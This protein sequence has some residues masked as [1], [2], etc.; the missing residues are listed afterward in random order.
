MSTTTPPGDD[1]PGPIPGSSETPP[2]PPAFPPPPVSDSSGTGFQAG[3]PLDEGRRRRI[4]TW[5]VIGAIVLAAVV[6]LSLILLL[7]GGGPDLSM[8]ESLA[9]EPQIHGPSVDFII[10][11]A[12]AQIEKQGVK[13]VVGVYG[14]APQPRFMVMAIDRAVPPGQDPLQ[15]VSTGFSA[16]MLGASG[17]IDTSSVRR[18]TVAG[19]DYECAPYSISSNQTPV[20][21]SA[22][23]CVWDDGETT[24]MI[25]TFDQSVDEESLSTQAHDAVVG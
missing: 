9:G 11:G 2:P 16:G 10:T 15:A 21:V 19:T 7:K 25:M 22:D 20:Q 24:G 23:I 18:Q 4:R 5:I 17:N 1:R 8:P 12:K 13:A 6:G 14:S 3:P